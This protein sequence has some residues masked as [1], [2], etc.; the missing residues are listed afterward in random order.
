MAWA[1]TA[2]CRRAN[3]QC[4]RRWCCRW[5]RRCRTTHQEPA[6]AARGWVLRRPLWKKRLNCWTMKGLGHSLRRAMILARREKAKQTEPIVK[7]AEVLL[8]VD[9]LG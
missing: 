2:R 8:V 3:E 1:A 9:F 7:N 5:P 4:R 6:G